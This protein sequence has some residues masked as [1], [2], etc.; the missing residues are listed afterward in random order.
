[1]IDTNILSIYVTEINIKWNKIGRSKYKKKNRVNFSGVCLSEFSAAKKKYSERSKSK[2]SFFFVTQLLEVKLSHYSVT[3]NSIYIFL[4]YFFF[5]VS[6]EKLSRFK[7]NNKFKK[8]F[9]F[10]FFKFCLVSFSI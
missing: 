1:M 2:F 8:H 3:L 5:R 10:F 4:D 7:K 6:I 9:N